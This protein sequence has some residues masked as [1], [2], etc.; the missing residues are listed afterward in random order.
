[1]GG[2]DFHQNS[3]PRK[4]INLNDSTHHYNRYLR[5][6]LCNFQLCMSTG[7]VRDPVVK[8]VVSVGIIGG[9]AWW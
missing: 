6:R 4:V 7:R 5:R 9:N 8:N 2:L 1:M 3:Q